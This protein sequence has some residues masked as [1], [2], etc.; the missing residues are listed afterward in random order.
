MRRT[1]FS[2]TEFQSSVSNHR[3]PSMVTDPTYH[4][5]KPVNTVRDSRSITL[6]VSVLEKE[7]KKS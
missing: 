7:D 2:T 5:S 6:C 1:I 4:L 3:S